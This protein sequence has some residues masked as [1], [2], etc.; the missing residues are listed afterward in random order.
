MQAEAGL[1]LMESSAMSSRVRR[2]QA[3]IECACGVSERYVWEGGMPMTIERF[4]FGTGTGEPSA[5]AGKKENFVVG[6]F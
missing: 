4:M 5:A 6:T 3:R 2:S 1:L